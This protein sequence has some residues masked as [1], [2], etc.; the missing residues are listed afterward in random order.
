MAKCTVRNTVKSATRKAVAR[1]A[2]GAP[3]PVGFNLQDNMNDSVSILGTDAAGAESD[4]SGVATFVTVSSDPTVATVTNS[5]ATYTIVSVAPGSVTFTTTATWTDTAAGI[6]PFTILDPVTV[7]A[8]PITGL[9]LSHGPA[10]I[11]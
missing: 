9:A 8:G 4:I 10:T 7:T 1:A 11:R 5:G 2:A 6:G 3:A